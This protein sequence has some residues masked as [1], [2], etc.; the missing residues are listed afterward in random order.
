MAAHRFSGS[1]QLGK[2]GVTDNFIE[3][4][5]SYF[6]NHTQVRIS[7][8]RSATRNKEEL[9]KINEKILDALGK[10]FKSRVIGYTLV[11]NKFKKSLRE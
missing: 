10:N 7:V 3:T 2:Q 1:L 9:K 11:I 5:K 6:K 8:L 4:L